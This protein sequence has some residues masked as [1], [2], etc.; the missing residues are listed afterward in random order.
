MKKP[1]KQLVRAF[2]WIGLLSFVLGACQNDDNVNPLTSKEQSANTAKDNSQIMAVT[3]DVMSITDGII[4]T[5]DLSGGRTADGDHHDGNHDDDDDDD[6][7]DD[8]RG[9]CRP[10][11]SGSFNL[12]RSH[13]DSLI[14]TGVFVVDFGDGSTCDSTRMRK[15][16][17]ID[18]VT[19]IVSFKDSITFS[20]TETITFEGFWKD[21]VQVDG[22][23]IIRSS[24][25]NPTTVEAQGAKITYADGTSFSWD[26]TL[27]YVY[28]KK[29]SRHCKGKTMKI[30]EGTITGITRSGAD[31]TATITEE[32]V[33]KRCMGKH[34]IPVSGTIEVTTAGTPS[35]L[36]FG[37]G[38]C[39]K[40]F[41]ITTGGV[42]TPH[43]F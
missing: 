36:D 5:R 19:V 3:E 33:Y 41:T 34:F 20:S 29:G 38:T 17:V 43:T 10:S 6:G 23:F 22:V 24:S 37:D 25:G 31:F 27:T 12:D 35:T 26:G 32:I 28:Y 14:Y 15:G 8:S 1:L 40:D 2:R 11:I 39:D 30:T 7:D 18:S 9:G 4:G 42:P 13:P 21:S 16:K